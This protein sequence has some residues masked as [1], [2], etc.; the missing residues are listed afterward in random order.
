MGRIERGEVN[1]TV[2]KLFIIARAL[3]CAPQVLLPTE[4]EV[5]IPDNNRF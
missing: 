3:Q 1:I 5:S 4:A 2:E